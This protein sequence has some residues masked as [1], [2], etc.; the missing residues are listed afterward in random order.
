L[1]YL[2]T[3]W[4]ISTVKTGYDIMHRTTNLVGFVECGPGV[5]RGEEGEAG[6]RE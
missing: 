6:Q 4:N 5:E 1:V 3:I 2:T